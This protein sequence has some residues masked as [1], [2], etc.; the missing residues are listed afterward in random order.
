MTAWGP[1]RGVKRRLLTDYAVA[2]LGS[3][4]DSYQLVDYYR[5]RGRLRVAGLLSPELATEVINP[6]MIKTE[7][8]A[9]PMARPNPHPGLP[10]ALVLNVAVGA[11]QY[12]GSMIDHV[13][14]N[15]GRVA[16]PPAQWGKMEI[17]KNALT[18]SNMVLA[19]LGA[20][21]QK[22]T[23]YGQLKRSL[24]SLTLE[25]CSKICWASRL[26]GAN[27]E[28]FRLVSPQYRGYF[29]WVSWEGGIRWASGYP[30]STPF[31]I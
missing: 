10:N 5:L 12:M 15:I 31:A 16:C 28:D 19:W 30:L 6:G 1:P 27:R 22:N 24:H 8:M 11:L 13:A 2:R 25:L 7:A 29:P 4:R 20:P 3:F 17:H 23:G 21:D 9:H 26:R 18:A 14:R